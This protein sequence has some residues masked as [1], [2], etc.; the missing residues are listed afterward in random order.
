MDNGSSMTITGS[1][2]SPEDATRIIRHIRGN[3]FRGACQLTRHLKRYGPPK[4]RCDELEEMLSDDDEILEC[5]GEKERELK[6]C[7]NYEE[8][9][10]IASRCTHTCLCGED[11]H[12]PDECPM[13]KVTCFLCEGTYHVPMDCQLNLVLAKANEDQRTT[14]QPIRQPMAVGNN[15]HN[16]SAVSPTPT[17]VEANRGS[18]NIINVVLRSLL[19]PVLVDSV[20]NQE[21]APREQPSVNCF[22]YLEPGNCLNKCPLPRPTT[23]VCRCFNCGETGHLSEGC[24]MPKRRYPQVTR[25]ICSTPIPQV[26]TTPAQRGQIETR[27]TRKAM[28]TNRHL[29]VQSPPQRIIVKGTVKGRIVPPTTASNP[30]NQHQQGKQC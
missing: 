18:N 13:Q 10:H 1:E 26:A 24:P 2:F 5:F 8:V 4:P 15:G 3:T 29:N 11:T 9:G 14:R 17:P 30:Q 6:A 28:Y 19:D 20:L 16:Y 27:H 22:N 12:L 25:I 23:V 21:H 7:T